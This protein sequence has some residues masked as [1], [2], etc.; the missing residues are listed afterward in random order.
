MFLIVNPITALVSGVGVLLLATVL[1]WPR[2]GVLARIGQSRL[3]ARRALLEDALKFLFDCEY[4]SHSCQLNGIAGSLHISA[5]RAA[6]LLESL[7]SLG[8]ITSR[9]DTFRLTDTGRS[10]ALRV[11]RV[12][13]IWE[14]YLADETGVGHRE[15][16]EMADTAEHH[17]SPEAVDELAAR[18]GN[19]VFDPHGDP[20]PSA[21]GKIPD[22]RGMTLS[23]A[24]EGQVLRITHIEDEPAAIYDQLTA[25]G[26]YPGMQLYVMD[27]Q[28]DRI[29]FAANGESC[30]LTPLFA[31]GITVEPLSEVVESSQEK[32]PL[33]S[34]LDLGERA[35]IKR[36]SPTFRGQQ[37]R[38]LMDMGVVPGT[39]IRAVFRS[40]SGDP[41]AYQ[42]LGAT[43][44][45]RK[46]QAD[47]IYIKKTTSPSKQ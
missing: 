29:T 37:R 38:R 7:Q 39:P 47:A 11:V 26:L 1:L 16:H 35:V 20:I 24:Q 18:L 19:P 41:V 44:A 28:E 42:I 12:H 30:V 2:W 21:D 40:A 22:Y 27:V 31:S 46:E 34:S 8:L 4:K 17:L 36:I 5:D 3:H 45:I 23:A 13:R 33:L 6:R 10:Y 9:G 15:W 32:Y 25:L 43:L 14:R